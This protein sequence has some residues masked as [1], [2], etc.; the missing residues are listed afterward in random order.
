MT[1]TGSPA[2]DPV[3]AAERELAAAEEVYEGDQRWTR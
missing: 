3:A 1:V 2:D